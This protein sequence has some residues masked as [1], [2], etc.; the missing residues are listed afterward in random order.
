MKRIGA[1]ISQVIVLELGMGELEVPSSVC[2]SS[3]QTLYR[4]SRCANPSGSA[5]IL[6]QIVAPISR[7]TPSETGVHV[8]RGPANEPTETTHRELEN[9][10]FT[11]SPHDPSSGSTYEA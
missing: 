11:M 1:H 9:L 6:Q 4:S 2:L 10:A 8:V 5:P 3:D 7:A